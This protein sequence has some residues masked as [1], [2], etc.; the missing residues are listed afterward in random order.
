MAA[1]EVAMNRTATPEAPWLLVPADHQWFHNL[2]VAEAL[3]ARLRP[4]RAEWLA[5]RDR[6]GREKRDE[7]LEEA[8]DEV[9]A[10]T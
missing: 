2:A 9:R 7:A 6:I 1:Y 5:E 10:A 8:P 3:V 4:H